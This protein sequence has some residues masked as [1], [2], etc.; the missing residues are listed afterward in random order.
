MAEPMKTDAA[1]LNQGAEAF[2]SVHQ[3]LTQ[4]RSNVDTTAGEL[5]QHVVGR[6]GT[7]IQQALTRYNEKAEAQLKVLQEIQENIRAAG[8]HYEKADDEA[9]SGMTGMMNF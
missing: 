5:A 1:A 7:A 4:V 9:S 6:T 3:S 2:G 8:G